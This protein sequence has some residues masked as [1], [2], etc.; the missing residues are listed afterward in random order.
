VKTVIIGGG[1]GC[2]AILDLVRGAFLRELTLEVVCVA[3]LDPDAPG[4]LRAH[5]LGIPTSTDPMATLLMEGL[6]LVIELTGLDRVVEEIYEVLPPGARLIDHTIAHVFWDL[7]NA[8]QEQEWHL[9]EITNLEEKIETERRFLLSLFNTIP[10]LVV[11]FDTQKRI[12]RTNAAFLKF[13]GRSADQLTGSSCEDLLAATELAA[14]QDQIAEVVDEV[15]RSAKPRSLVWQTA[16]P[17]E[18]YW[19]VAHTPIIGRDGTPEGVVGTW[20]RITERIMLV[21]EIEQA[22]QRFKA[23]IDSAND[24]ISIKDL[25]GRYVIVNPVCAQAFNLKAEDFIGRR[26]EEILASDVADSIRKHDD[27]V[28]R[29]NRYHTFNEVYHVQGRDRHFQTVRFPLTD[30]SGETVGVCTIARDITSEKDLNEQLVQAAKLAAVGKLAAGVAHEINN[31]LTGILAFA[32][33]LMME[34]PEDHTHRH[35]LGVIVRET[36]RCREIVRNL[37]DFARLEKLLLEKRNPNQVVAEALLLVHKL[38]QFR[39]ITITKDPAPALPLVECDLPQLQQ[40][41][42]NLMLNAA[43]AM[44]GQGSIT[45]HTGYNITADRCIIA[46]EDSGPGVP[47][48]LRSRVFEPFFSTKGANGLGLAVSLGIIERHRGTIEVFKAP[49]GGAVFEIS[50]PAVPTGPPGS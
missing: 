35:D 7:A 15:L 36:I 5:E 18:A 32:E 13:S 20:H 46:V 21:R 47:E 37:L 6:E 9:V 34:L 1:K 27:D 40:V 44:A 31:P 3:D 11:V 29:D 38:P 41:I 14:A 4:M 16:Y 24:W 26:P 25:E 19:E 45:I 33:D 12:V 8:K 39:N 2:V 50:L 48:E 43:E 28:I 22:E 23:F 17:K 42:L 49:S 30:H 10:D